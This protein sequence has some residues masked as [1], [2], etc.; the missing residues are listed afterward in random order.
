MDQKV[1]KQQLLKQIYSPYINCNGC[2]L[3]CLGRNHV[4]FG[5]GNPDAKLMF[6]GE[7]PGRDEDIQGRPFVGRSGKLLD[8]SLEAVGIKRTDVYITNIVKCR[9]PNNRTPT[10][11]E[12]SICKKLLLS[13]Q[14]KI[15]RPHVICTLG[16]AS[17]KGLL[18]K[19]NIK[20][21]QMRGT[22]IDLDGYLVVPTYH[23]AYILRNPKELKTLIA[24]LELARRLSFSTDKG[25]G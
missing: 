2:P 6:I 17:L 24:D 1:F 5:E 11:I 8:R 23:P 16:A 14:I 13:K 7:A 22:T 9:P 18:E 20:I 10:E 19:E 12:S 21:T 15:I 4:I 3:G 25:G